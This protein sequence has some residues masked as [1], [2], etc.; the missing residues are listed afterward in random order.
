[1][2]VRERTRKSEVTELHVAVLINKYV[3][4]LDVTVEHVRAPK[5]LERLQTVA[6][7]RLH[8][9]FVERL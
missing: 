1:M 9:L 6:K 7:E 8:M 2:A 3:V 5:E 4:R